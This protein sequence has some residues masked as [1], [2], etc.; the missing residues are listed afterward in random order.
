MASE[1]KELKKQ[2]LKGSY[3]PLKRA[4]DITWSLAFVGLFIPSLYNIYYHL[5]PENYWIAVV[6]FFVAMLL[7]DFFSGLAHWGADTWGNFDT[8]FF[9]K[10]FIRSFREHHLAPLAMTMHDVFETN[11]DNCLLTV[12]VLYLC[13]TANCMDGDKV[14][15]WAFFSLTLWTWVSLWVALTNQIHAW[16]HVTNPP[17]LV[18]ILQNA[19]IILPA[20]SHRKHHQIPFDRNYCITNG[21]AEYPLALIDF[22]RVAERFVHNTTGM[23][24]REDDYKWTGISNEMPDVVKRMLAS[25]KGTN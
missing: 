10:T 7:S 11:G 9:G 15:P 17:K 12:P 14:A 6:A 16:S 13:V 5:R 20:V 19:R 22:W 1:E 2:F 24:P 25:S 4:S 3:T 8:P 18:S 21:W 23:I